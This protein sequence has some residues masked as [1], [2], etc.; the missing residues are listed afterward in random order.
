MLIFSPSDL[1]GCCDECGKV[2]GCVAYSWSSDGFCRLKGSKSLPVES[3]GTYSALLSFCTVIETGVEYPGNDI[4]HLFNKNF[5]TVEDCCFTC[6]LVSGCKYFSYNRDT[7]ECWLKT[8]DANKG[9]NNVMISGS[10]IW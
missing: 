2:E 3:A 7:Q 1:Q 10:V 5:K 4:G 8:S 9:P 6:R